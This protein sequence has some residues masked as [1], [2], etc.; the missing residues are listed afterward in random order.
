MLQP[1]FS[2]AARLGVQ[3]IAGG[4]GAEDQK[5]HARHADGDGL[6][7]VV[8]RQDAVLGREGQDGHGR[9]GR[10]VQNDDAQ[11]H[12]RD[13]QPAVAGGRG[14][15]LGLEGGSAEQDRPRHGGDDIGGGPLDHGVDG[16]GRHA[17]EVHSR[18]RQA[19]H[20]AADQGRPLEPQRGHQQGR[21][22][23][24]DGDE[25][26]Q[27]RQARLIGDLD[28]RLIGDHGDEVGAPDRG[29]AGHRAQEDP[30]GARSGPRAANPL[31]QAY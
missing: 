4:A 11:D 25:Q 15:R 27:T 13:R 9:H 10:E 8:A 24:A 29:A 26:G 31:Q 22:A 30:G 14:Q 7:R 20:Q 23:S 19:E 21:A 28:A 18:H 17:D 3:G 1:D 6:T 2:L 5:A 16:E 12:Q